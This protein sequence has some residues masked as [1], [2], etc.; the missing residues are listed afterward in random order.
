VSHN[1]VMFS[2][3]HA[4]AASLVLCLGP[5]PAL[6]QPLPGP[7]PDFAPPSVLAPPQAQGPP[8]PLRVTTDTPEY[9]GHLAGRIATVQHTQLATHPEA[10]TL[11]AEGQHMCDIG[12][13]RGG[14]AR[15]RRALIMLLQ[16]QK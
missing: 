9:C 4:L 7:G 16:A 12:H 15:L 2:V 1:S 11:A 10:D 5:G 14:I 3:R 6:P 13:I 8:G